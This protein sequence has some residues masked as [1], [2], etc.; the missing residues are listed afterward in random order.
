VVE[1]EKRPMKYIFTIPNAATAFHLFRVG[2]LLFWREARGAE[3]KLFQIDWAL[4]MDNPEYKKYYD[5]KRE[6]GHAL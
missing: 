2:E 6:D 4:K 3:K 5:K 1:G